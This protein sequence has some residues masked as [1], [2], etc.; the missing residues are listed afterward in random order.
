MTTGGNPAPSAGGEPSASPFRRRLSLAI[1]HREKLT[2][3]L[4]AA[5]RAE[6]L[7]LSQIWISE[8]LGERGAFTTATAIAAQTETIS[9]G[10][11]VLNPQM[12]HPFQIAMEAATLQEYSK[13]RLVLGLG[14]GSK[15]A[16]ERSLGLPNGKPLSRLLEAHAQI[17]NVLSNDEV[18]A[19]G[20]FYSS[21]HELKFAT[22]E[23]P[24]PIVLGVKS[25]RAIEK[26]AR[27]ADGILLSL[28]S[29]PGYIRW[30]E[31][32]IPLNQSLSAY[33]MYAYSEDSITARTAARQLIARF[34]GIHG[35][36]DLIRQSGFDPELATHIRS[37]HLQN[38][39][40]TQ[41]IDDPTIDL[42][43]I[44]GDAEECAAGLNRFHEGNRCSLILRPLVD[45]PLE[46]SLRS[47]AL[48]SGYPPPTD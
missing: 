4:A 27:V 25:R 16:I 19:R 22:S 35:D 46:D 14:S 13:G 2:D 6:K 36:N 37:L 21:P 30:V 18:R 10:L 44:A 28:L 45:L 7:G 20:D 12:R 23:D 47:V 8:D 40:T 32:A 34:V 11:G 24:P 29:S 5:R 31:S 42:F 1:S 17:R 48:L 43:A 9:I 3:V 38:R 41:L 39:P 15:D 26:A 33:V